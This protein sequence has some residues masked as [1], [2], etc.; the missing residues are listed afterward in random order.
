[1]LKRSSTPSDTAG[2]LVSGEEALPSSAPKRASADPGSIGA[3]Q[4]TSD[5][6]N[7]KNMALLIQLRW[8]AV[9]GQIATIAFVDFWLGIALPLAA[10]S[11]VI[12]ALIT[13]N[14]TSMIWVRYRVEIGSR[15]L[16]LAL[17]LD[18]VALTIQLYL[19]GGAANPFTSLYLLQVTLGA[20][21]LDARSSW[22]LV[23]LSCVSFGWLTISYHPLEL[24]HHMDDPFSL[25]VAGMFVGFMLDAV[26][27]VIFVTR[28]NRNLRERDAHLAA[29]R[30]H[31]AEQDHIVRMGLLASGA[32]HEL[33]TPLAS[34]SVILSD[35][36]RMPKLTA[37]SE[38]ADDLAEM[39]ASLQRCKTIVTG[40]LVSAGQA[41]GEG[42]EPTTIT[43]FLTALVEEWREAR[44][45]SCLQ[46][47]NSVGT[48][49]TIVSDVTLKQAIFNVLDNA[50]EVSR[51]WVELAVERDGDT[52]VL[53]VSD[54]GPGFPPE[55]LSQLGRPY[56][57][58]KGRPG[59]GL[60]LFLV[61]NVIRKLG[62]VVT[63]QNHRKRGATIKLA[64]PLATLAIGGHF[65]E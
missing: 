30:Q 22:S 4:P 41:R 38:I 18:V 59:S 47:R 61:V 25:H 11:A 49:L 26:L 27:L 53:S 16:L 34:L 14:I 52:L 45:V 36:R 8:T 62:G 9:I 13:L 33:G 60:G 12:S 42:S 58:S 23:A 3:S 65:G 15:E 63:A 17:M 24:P 21:L 37:E 6:T 55:I 54:R 35:W 43:A 31:A 10:M 50:L 56:Q 28:I 64:L 2:T 57:S 48:D 20:V 29:L 1:M 39:E 44:S 7:R 40:I 5:T 19:S 46:F 51:D 32:A